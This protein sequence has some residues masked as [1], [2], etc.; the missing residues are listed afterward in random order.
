MAVQIEYEELS[1]KPFDLDTLN[2]QK[3]TLQ[4]CY[5]SLKVANNKLP[6]SFDQLIGKEPYDLDLG[7]SVGETAELKNAV[8][9]EMYEWFAIPKVMQEDEKPQSDAD[10]KNA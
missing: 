2:T 10:P 9:D 6:F 5:A 4:L 7:L 1:G 8:I 3:A